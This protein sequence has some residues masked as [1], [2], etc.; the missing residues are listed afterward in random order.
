MVG[1]APEVRR[2][3]SEGMKVTMNVIYRPDYDLSS[4]MEIT[5][6]GPQHQEMSAVPRRGFTNPR[7]SVAHAHSH[8]HTHTVSHIHIKP[9]IGL[10]PVAPEPHTGL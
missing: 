6:A 9:T 10:Q 1:S 5:C 2:T 8:T 7:P 3:V 4:T